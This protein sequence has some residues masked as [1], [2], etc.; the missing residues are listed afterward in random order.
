MMVVLSCTR[1]A[2]YQTCTKPCVYVDHIANGN[3]KRKE[4]HIPSDLL[5]R[6]SQ[7][8]YNEALSE[9]IEDK[10]NK[11]ANRL[12]YIRTIINYHTRLIA[13]AALADIPQRI[14]AKLTNHSQSRISQLYQS[15][16]RNKS[17]HQ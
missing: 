8:S 9:L 6:T 13:A 3:I 4:V 10:R 17:N 14:I 11:D 5:D 1:C 15:I 16:N 2:H 7:S 12:E